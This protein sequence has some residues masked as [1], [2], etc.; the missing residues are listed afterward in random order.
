MSDLASIAARL[1]EAA[2]TA[3]AT[4]Q[5]SLETDLGVEDAYRVQQASIQR[6]LDRGE[7]LVGVKMGLTSQAKMRQVGVHEVIWGHLT[8]AMRV[9][10]GG[11]I[12]FPRYVHPRAE[13]EVAFGLKHVLT[14]EVSPAEALAA[15]EWVA[16]AIEIIDSRYENF[17]FALPD[18]IADNA[19]SSSFVVGPPRRPDHPIDNE[20][21]VLEVDGQV[22]QTGSSA[23]ILGHPLRSLV[24]AAKL[25]AR[26]GLV[27]Q[28]GWIVLA[29]GATAAVPL[30]PGM[31][32]SLTTAT[33][34]RCGFGVA[35]E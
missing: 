34:G 20:G 26:L 27:L 10:D 31:Q 29:G 9:A 4:P 8:S 13:P 30:K 23:A 24:A 12:A 35:A 14:G 1:D 3:T 33:L 5:V 25:T 16:P 17:K 18:V 22:A 7:Q 15:V 2:R 6:R 21:M 32:V 11:R 28:P 19:S